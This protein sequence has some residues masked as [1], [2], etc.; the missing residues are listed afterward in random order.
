ML[1]TPAA[2]VPTGP[3]WVHEVKW[4][5]MRVLA[6]IHGGQLTLTSRTGNDVTASYPELAGLADTYDDLLL[7]GEVV[8]LQE[9]RPSFAALAD[10]M[11][12]ADRRR[13]ERLAAVRPVTYMVFDLLRLFGEDLTG[14]PLSARRELLERLDLTGRHWQ[15]PPVYPDGEELF[16]ATLEQGLEGVV[17]KRLGSAYVPGRRSSE[18]LKSPHRTTI[19]AVVGG[20]RP[21]RTN[22]AGRLGAVLLGVPTAQGWRYAGRM[23]SGIAGAAQ[24]QLAALLEPLRADESPFCDEVPAMDARGAVWVRPE[25]VVEARVLEVT[26]DGRLRQ[27]AYLGVRSDLTA[28]DLMAD[29]VGGEPR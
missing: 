8:A 19:S 20:W 3:A 10:R 6:D 9:G 12:V 11:H 15:V 27:P 28:D 14:Q 26:R 2:A 23:G 22:D 21:E 24:R 5:G 16:R 29:A 4:D 18:W 17:S 13:A 25:V 1:A 7:D